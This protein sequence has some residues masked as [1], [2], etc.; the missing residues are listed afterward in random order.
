MNDV[1]VSTAITISGI[2]SVYFSHA[3]RSA[4][5]ASGGSFTATAAA[6]NAV[7]LVARDTTHWV[8]N[9]YN[10]TWTAN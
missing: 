3:D 4:Y 10:G 1:A 2:T 5:G 8:V 7:C 9:S 6:G